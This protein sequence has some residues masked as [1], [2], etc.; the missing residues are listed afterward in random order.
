MD[1]QNPGGGADASTV[2]PTPTVGSTTT[3]APVVQT[4]VAA[5]SKG[6]WAGFQKTLR[7]QTQLIAS[8]TEKLNSLGGPAKPAE[9]AKPADA[10][11]LAQQVADLNRRISIR[12]ALAAAGVSDPKVAAR[13]ERVA[14]AENPQDLGAFVSEFI[15]D[16]VP[17]KTVAAVPV[18]AP[19][20]APIAPSNTGQPAPS[21]AQA[22]LPENPTQWPADVVRKM[23]PIEFR[24]ALDA[25]D[26][27]H[28]RGDPLRLLRRKR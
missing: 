27:K 2:T 5:P 8:I 9:P 21:P 6:D 23:G 17:A 10:S 25:Y 1:P 26:A 24:K 12:D 3:T 11:A 16:F 20:A 22:Q 19:V 13:V 7:E 4:E 18:S 15:A 14:K 28:G